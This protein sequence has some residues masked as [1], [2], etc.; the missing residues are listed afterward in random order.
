MVP[1]D[2]IFFSKLP[3]LLPLLF[4]DKIVVISRLGEGVVA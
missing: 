3:T 4:E 1:C 2:S